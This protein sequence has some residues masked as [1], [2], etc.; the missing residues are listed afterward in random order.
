MTQSVNLHRILPFLSTDAWSTTKVALVNGRNALAALCVI[1]NKLCKVRTYTRIRS[2]YEHVLP[3]HVYIVLHSVR[4][5]S[6][7]VC[8]F[9][10]GDSS[11]ERLARRC[12]CNDTKNVQR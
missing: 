4:S 7:G 11:S 12:G 6:W 10:V 9:V 1:T 8:E 5:S 3:L 2:S